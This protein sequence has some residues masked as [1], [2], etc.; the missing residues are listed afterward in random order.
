M[1]RKKS[2]TASKISSSSAPAASSTT[3]IAHKSSI[4]HSRFSPSRFQTPLFAS[5]IQGID[6]QHL[7]FHDTRTA[8]LQCEHAIQSKATV[9]C[10]DW[11]YYGKIH[12][13]QDFELLR[14]K[15]KREDL[16][17]GKSSDIV[18]EDVVLAFGTSDSEINMFSP[19]RAKIV[20]VLKGAH[21]QGIRDFKFTDGGR[22]Q[23]G[24]SIGGEGKLI[25]WNLLKGTS[26][27]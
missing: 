26:I 9:T 4:L 19:A 15:R 8:R 16:V 2:Q 21:T 10:L 11:G 7:R 12:R 3:L 23:E 14:K 6:S 25:Q 27:R 20:A 17:N 5:V 13:D 1:G 18:T 22:G 24:W